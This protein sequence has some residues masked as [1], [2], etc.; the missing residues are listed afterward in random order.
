MGR[1]L[2]ASSCRMLDNFWRGRA[3]SKANMED[4]EA[5]VCCHSFIY[6]LSKYL[7]NVSLGS[8]HYSSPEDI[9]LSTA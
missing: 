6:S 3:L 5:Q 4:L 9:V 1:S 7:L 8:R 2:W